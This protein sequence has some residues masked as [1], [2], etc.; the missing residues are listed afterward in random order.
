MS[1]K[2]P[3]YGVAKGQLAVFYHE[4]KV[5]GSAWIESTK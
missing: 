4:E 2:E 3:V 5:I 1:L